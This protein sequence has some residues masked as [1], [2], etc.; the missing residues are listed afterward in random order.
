MG[1]IGFK[2]KPAKSK[3]KSTTTATKVISKLCYCVAHKEDNRWKAHI[4]I[5]TDD[6]FPPKLV[7]DFTEDSFKLYGRERVFVKNHV[8]HGKYTM[9][10]RDEYK[11]KCFPGNTDLYETLC[12]NWVYSGHIVQKDNVRYFRIKEVVAPESFCTEL[13]DNYKISKI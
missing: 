12:N 7:L 9:I 6:E 10:I 3:R 5:A 8:G 2:F 11:C 4:S 13:I 1:L